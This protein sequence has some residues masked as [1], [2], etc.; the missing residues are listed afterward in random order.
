MADSIV[1]VPSTAN[2]DYDFLAFSFNGL[3]SWDDFKIYRTNSGDRY[4]LPTTGQIK[5]ITVEVPGGDG[6]YYFESFHKEK[7]FPI[8]FAFDNL[9]ET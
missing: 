8:S 2:K 7:K 6:L 1:K 3:H 9:T 4:E 5:D